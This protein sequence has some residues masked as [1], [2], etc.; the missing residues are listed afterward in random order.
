MSRVRAVCRRLGVERQAVAMRRAMLP[1]HIRADIRDHELL[2]ALL[3]RVLE[4]DSDCIDIGASTGSVLREMVRL[5]PRG[6]H[7]AFEPLPD[8]A[9]RL[10]A[11]FPN[12]E[13][14]EAALA[15]F[16]GH[17]D[18]QWATDEPGWSGFHARPTPRGSRFTTLSVACE[19]LDDALPDGISPRLVKIDVEGAEEGVIR[20]AM[21][22]LRRCRPVLVFEH[23]RG[24]AE[25]YETRPGDHPRSARGRPRLPDRGTRR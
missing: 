6:H 16:T 7:V 10:R 3:E 15:D 17:A 4:P 19:R 21:S 13:V 23:A 5:A 1:A 24:G 22:T 18:F 2:V 12:V 14:H 20:G 8:H 25:L 9:A 11:E